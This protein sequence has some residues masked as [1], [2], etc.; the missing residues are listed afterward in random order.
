M[1]KVTIGPT[2]AKKG[3]AGAKKIL[4]KRYPV[5]TAEIDAAIALK[6]KKDD[7]TKSAKSESKDPSKK[8]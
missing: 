6:F 7:K 3:E 2:L 4:L 1:S 8:G 5:M